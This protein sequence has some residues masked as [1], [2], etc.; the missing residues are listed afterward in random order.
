LGKKVLTPMVCP[1]QQ[2][3]TCIGIILVFPR[4]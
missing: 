3:S 4:F 2:Q 1:R